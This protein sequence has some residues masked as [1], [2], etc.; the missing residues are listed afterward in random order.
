MNMTTDERT[1]RALERARENDSN[2]RDATRRVTSP[3]ISGGSETTRSRTERAL[4]SA[5]KKDRETKL[6]TPSR[7]QSGSAGGQVSSPMISGTRSSVGQMLESTMNRFSDRGLV[8]TYTNPDKWDTSS[9]AE[10]GMRQWS[11]ELSDMEQRLTTQADSLSGM[12]TEL[13]TLENNLNTQANVDRYNSLVEQ[14]NSALET[15]SRDSDEYNRLRD[16][17]S[18][19]L[20]KYRDILSSGMERANEYAAEAQLLSTRNSAIEDELRRYELGLPYFDGLTSG[21]STGERMSRLQREYDS[22]QARIDQLLS[23]AD[24]SRMEYYSSLRMAEDWEQNSAAIGSQRLAQLNAGE[25]PYYGGGVVYDY[26]NDIGGARDSLRGYDSTGTQYA[27]YGTMTPDEI[28][29]YN[30]LYATQGADAAEEFLSEMRETLNYRLGTQN[31]ENMSGFGKALYWIPAGLSQFT[32]GIEQLFSREAVPTSP[33]LYTSSMIQ[34][35]AQAKSPVLGTLYEL[36]T[37]L[38]NMAPSVLA[39]A[40]GGWALGGTGMAAGTAARVAGLGGSAMLGASAGGNAYTQAL[41]EGRSTDEARTYATLIGASEGAFQY[42]LGGIGSLGGIGV[43]S[44]ASKIGALDNVLG[45]IASSTAGKLVGNMISE[46]TEEG[47]QELLEPAIRTLV[48]DEEYN[49]D[50]EDV[51]YSF[52]LGA[53]SAG[54]IDAPGAVREG[55]QQRKQPSAPDFSIM[56]GYIGEDGADNFQGVRTLEELDARYME[57][58]E[59][60]NAEALDWENI[61]NQYKMARTFLIGMNAQ[62]NSQ[63]QEASSEAAAS[64]SETGGVVL[65]TSEELDARERLASATDDLERSG[66]S[67]GV[68]EENIAAAQRISSALGRQVRFYDGAAETGPAQVANGYYLDGTIYVNS[69]STNPV[70]QII[71]H[72]LTHSVEMADAYGELS[73]LVLDHIQQSGVD[74]QQLR[75]SKRELYERNGVQLSSDADIDSE[76][77]AEYIEKNLLTDEVSIRTLTQNNRSLGERILAWLNELL[78]RLGNA[79]ARERAFVAEAR[80]A[81]SRALAETAPAEQ[82]QTTEQAA[83]AAE[84]NAEQAPEP[85]T[86]TEANTEEPP[87]RASLRQLREDY[88]AGRLTDEEFDSALDAIEEQETL[89]GRS[90]FDELRYSFGGENA[91]RANMASLEQAQQMEEQQVDAE[92]IRQL[93]GWFRGAYDKWRFEIDDSGMR[94]EPRGDLNFGDPDYQR[95][96]EL[97]NRLEAEMLDLGGTPLTEAEHAEFSELAT[98][99]SDYYRRPGVRGDGSLPST[100][101][102]DYVQHD[103]LFEQ[104][105]QLRDATLRF[106]ELDGGE[107]GSY[108]RETNTVTLDT[109]LRGEARSDTLVHEIQHAIQAQEGFAGGSS[110][111][112]WARLDYE[113]GDSAS[114]RLQRE[115]RALFDSLSRDE[116]NKYTRYRELDRELNRLLFSNP[117]TEEAAQYARYEAEQDELYAELYSNVWFRELIDLERRIENPGDE[118]L[119]MYRN[120]AGE[121][122]ARDAAARR[123]LTAEERRATPPDTGDE[124]TVFVEENLP[125]GYSIDENYERDIDDWDSRGRPDGEAFILGETGDVL[126]GLGA[127]EQDIYLRS[128]KVN[129][130][131]EK[132]PEMTL[133]EIKRIPEVLDDP[134]LVLSSSNAGRRSRNSRLVIF[135]EARAQNGQPIMAVLDLQPV[136]NRIIINDM[137]KVNSAYTRNNAE[138]YIRKSKVLYADEDKTMPLLSS[139]ENSQ[140][141][142][143]SS[144]LAHTGSGGLLRSGYVG[145]ISYENGGVNIEGVPFDEVVS[146]EDTPQ[147]SISRQRDRGEMLD[148][149]RRY[150]NGEIDTSEIRAYI[151]GV[152]DAQT[153]ESSAAQSI[154]DQAHSEGMSVDEYLR[155]NWDEYEYDGELNETARRAL[156]LERE[157]ARRRYSVSDPERVIIAPGGET[158]IE[159][160]TD[161]EYRAMSNETYQDFPWL[162]NTGETVVNVRQEPDG[163]RYIWSK[164]D[165]DAFPLNAQYSVDD[166]TVLPTAAQSEYDEVYNRMPAKVRASMRR[167]ENALLTGLGKVLSVPN[168]ERHGELR[169]VVHDLELEYLNSGT[170]SQ[171]VRDELFTRAYDAGVVI[172]REFYDQYKGVRDYLRTTNIDVGSEVQADIPDFNDFRDSMLGRMKIRT[173]YGTNIDQ[174]YQDLNERW[175]ELFPDNIIVPSDQL[176]KMAEAAQNIEVV[177]RSLDEYAGRDAKMFRE[178]MRREF[179]TM[180]AKLIGELRNVQRYMYDQENPDAVNASIPVPQS[181]EEAAELWKQVK[182]LRR[183]YERTMSRYLLTRS[184]EQKVNDLMRGQMRLENLDPETDNVA[185]ITA[186]YQAKQAYEAVIKPLRVWNQQRK[187]QLRERADQLLENAND[188][189]DKRAG[190]MYSR[191]T[192]ERNTRD[193]VTDPNDA[194]AIISEYFTPVHEATANANRMKNSYRDRVRALDLS[195]RVADG[196]VVSEAHAVQLLGEAEDNIRMMEQSRG[197]IKARDGKSL[198]DW[199]AIV[200]NL[201]KENPNLDEQK[202]RGAVEEFRAIYDELFQQMN[203]V[204]VRNGYEPINYRSGY[205]PHFQPGEGDGILSQ[206]GRVLGIDTQVTALP[207]TINGLTHTFRPGITWFGNAQER[208]GFNTVYDAVE[209]FDKYIEGVSD[210]ITQTDNIQRLR[211][212]ASQI[213]YRTSDEGLRKQIDAINA[214]PD[215]TEEDKQ[216]RLEKL[217]ETGRYTLSHFVVEL[218]EYTNLLANKKS[219]ADRNME[220]AFG[221]NAYNLVKALESRVAANMVAINPA[222]WLTNFVPLTQGWA[223]VGSGDMLKGMWQTLKAMKADDGIIDKS[224]FLTNRVGSDPIVQTYEQGAEPEK[225]RERAARAARVAF[226]RASDV[227]SSPMEYIDQFVAGSLVRA[228]YNQNLG[229]GMS[230]AAA[231][232]D[233]DAFAANVMADRSKGAVPTLFQRSNPLTKVFT[234]FQLEV[235]NQLSYIFKDIPRDM[236]ERGVKAMAGALIKFALGAWLF[237]ELYEWLIGRRPALDPI[238][239]LNDTVGDL[240]GW[241]VPNLVDLGLGAISGNVPSFQVEQTGVGEAGVNLA[242]QIAENLP[243]IGGLLG[244]GRLP[245]S[246]AIPNVGNAWNALTNSEWSTEKRLQELGEEVSPLLTYLALPFGGGQLN[247]IYD[248]IRAVSEGGVYTYNNEGE[249]LLQYP[250]YTDSTGQ[251]IANALAAGVFGTTSLP[252]GRE[253]IEEGFPTLTAEQTAVYQGM[254]EAGVSGEDAY[255]LIQEIRD[256]D[257]AE[258]KRYAIQQADIS[259]DGKSVAYY[260]LFANDKEKALMDEM[261][262]AGADMGEVTNTLIGIKQAASLKGAEETDFKLRAIIAADLTDDEKMQIYRGVISDKQDEDILSFLDAGL[263]FDQYLQAK[264]EYAIIDEN[265]E[266]SDERAVEFAGWVNEQDFTR[267]QA[268]VVQQLAPMSGNLG[269]L[270]DAGMDIESASDVVQTLDSLGEDATS[271]EEYM[272]IAQMPISE[273]EKELALEAIMSESAFEKYE[274]A[275]RAGVD[276]YDYCLF[277]DTI[278]GYSGDGRQEQVWAYIDS[279]P[280]TSAQKDALHLAAGYKESTLSKT[281]WH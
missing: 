57:M 20:T 240:T 17:Y 120:T 226:G 21:V 19:G 243:F 65:P 167:E 109:S 216:N 264:R 201:W 66:I 98:R 254:L 242:E 129:N 199:R 228:R 62:E 71:A 142:S 50:F 258:G 211:A 197:R 101:L 143:S 158:I 121:I 27:A 91:R 110:P 83:P 191:E 107:L 213:R 67:A 135:S 18:R 7:E 204:R 155:Q 138:N 195:R 245:I 183:A 42:L 164:S 198:S 272:A 56:E 79:G 280:L 99:Y 5:K 12:Q 61:V 244:G 233:A 269:K 187:A 131:M 252:T 144:R 41:N 150:V 253:W 156:E 202:I 151:D 85:E 184:D 43:R 115:Y 257:S 217:Y 152:D 237:D 165:G 40:L 94:F 14:Y 189:K 200:Q 108:N 278:A 38:S 139:I 126:Q 277:L 239:I 188:W 160:P 222:S 149:L 6:I 275:N 133:S 218:E 246:S 118:Y 249:R 75:Q 205:F 260:G 130:I 247:R 235:N 190:I 52:L 209:G 8:D 262:G 279:M 256:I 267:D 273:S 119:N 166:G 136:E 32:S 145:S 116:Q 15:Y 127:R 49:A 28:G 113:N 140:S 134:I 231:M 53:L 78:A 55:I 146:T 4:Q 13:S 192:M 45:R 114:E 22:N 54:I 132:H 178:A 39:S 123:R 86:D 223:G 154:I 220:Q 1:R 47:L 148:Q 2:N 212:L 263:S 97:R 276:T 124:N 168:A 117:G 59:S 77:V 185:G 159:N 33:T 31:Y 196:N 172:D 224:T 25:T 90:A 175:P 104:Y 177:Q 236:R 10:A 137:Q 37:T 35:E 105:P 89:E 179:D 51:A 180:V 125:A 194:E 34:Q 95:Y 203:D 238:G 82:S 271:T 147:Y 103:E 181:A 112:Y 102:S 11:G 173:R 227:L 46:G 234:Q 157:Q 70:A 16:R 176:L 76:I 270:A 36:G 208:I 100:R 250:L 268:E 106:A 81:Y 229:K 171:E 193:I 259:G 215:I 169:D 23:D 92:T 153:E 255:D 266:D 64:P 3:A 207:T 281:P 74:L 69:R 72:E 274:R 128:E 232:A 58:A 84:S 87:S 265:T 111:A 88:A 251:A 93:T 26:I 24:K 170:V 182:P 162:W 60:E 141:A 225:G 221:R 214:N 230:E 163:T 30:Y 9:E 68:S 122:E 48:F 248:A 96:R 261:A 80:D 73:S 161:S 206:F 210:V 174:V 241:E 44:I 186:V 219:R 63:V 29:I